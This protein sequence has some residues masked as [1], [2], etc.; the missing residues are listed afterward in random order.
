MVFS[1]TFRGL[2]ETSIKSEGLIC[3]VHANPG[4]G[5]FPNSFFEEVCLT[6]KTDRFHPFKWA[7]LVIPAG[8]RRIPV[9]SVP[10]SFFFTGITIPVPP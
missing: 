2:L 5:V 9:F 3:T 6:L 7:R 10:V 4:F 8:F 1:I